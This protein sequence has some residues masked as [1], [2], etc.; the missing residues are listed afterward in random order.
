MKKF[1]LSLALTFFSLSAFAE[2]TNWHL[3]VEPLFGMK[4][5]Q[6]DEYVFLKESNFSDDKLSELNWEIKPELYGGIKVRGGWKGFFEETHFTAGI[7]M[8][9]GMMMDSDWQNITISAAN[10]GNTVQTNYSESDNYLDYDFSFGF[11]GGYEFRVREWLKIKPSVAFEYQ[12]IKFTAKGGTA[13]Y[14]KNKSDGSS[15]PYDD[16]EHQDVYDFGDK[17]VISYNRT[18]DYLWLGSDF[19][20]SLPKIP[21]IPGNFIVNTGF[22]FAPYVYAV[23]FDNHFLKYNTGKPCDFADKTVDYFGAL[24]WNFGV[25][26]K[27][28]HRHSFLL[29][30][31]YFYMRILRGE[32]WEKEN[33]QKNYSISTSLDGGAGAKYFDLSLSYRFTIF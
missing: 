27:I 28:T 2:K 1:L 20:V 29:T 18:A 31:N 13:W 9:S 26:Y 30:V 33:T 10:G 32:D 25:E 4:W 16:S 14:G 6:V 7:P 24:K 5:G 3:S 19:S 22:F 8:K 15:Y 21:K 11:K 12:N 17:K 23:S